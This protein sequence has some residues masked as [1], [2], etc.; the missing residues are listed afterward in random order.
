M[1][2]PQPRP[3]EYHWL[4]PFF[5]GSYRFSPGFTSDDFWNYTEKNFPLTYEWFKARPNEI[6]QI[7]KTWKEL[8]FLRVIGWRRSKRP[9]RK[10]GKIDTYIFTEIAHDVIGRVREPT[11]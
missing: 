9:S 1:L 2:S 4:T 10:G 11:R 6:G 5:Y 7:F 8:K 3:P